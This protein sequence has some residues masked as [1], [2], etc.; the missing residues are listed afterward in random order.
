[1]MKHNI[2]NLDEFYS[3]NSIEV[4]EKI[5]GKEMHYHSA[6]MN[7]LGINPMEYAIMEL[8]NYIPKKSKILDCGCGWGAPAKQI[9][10]DLECEITGVTISKSQYEHIK[11]FDVIHS[12]LHDLKISGEY[13]IALF[14]ESYSHLHSPTKV[15]KNLRKHV[16]KI[17][18]RDYMNDEGRYIKYD[19]KWKMTIPN[20][21]KY[22]D[23]LNKSGFTVEYFDTRV[24][25]YQPEASYWL[26]N[27]LSLEKSEIY[28][29]VELLKNSCMAALQTYSPEYSG[30]KICTIVAS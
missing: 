19:A 17:I 8:Y 28:G 1:M 12:D 14:I 22:V 27:I 6:L 13:D 25:H 30:I 26:N 5:L 29:Q 15:L 23:D 7:D 4:W 11:D 9:M 18:I 21:A 10:R 2:L 3:E 24:H 20:K 16:D